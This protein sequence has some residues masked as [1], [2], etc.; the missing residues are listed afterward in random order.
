VYILS[1]Q[2]CYILRKW[3]EK[4]SY[5]IFKETL[6]YKLF[7]TYLKRSFIEG[8]GCLLNWLVFG[9]NVNIVSQMEL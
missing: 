5:S 7:F 3:E 2:R 8:R 6:I 9:V 4:F 1:I